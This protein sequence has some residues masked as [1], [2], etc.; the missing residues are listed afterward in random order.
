MANYNEA[1]LPQ[2]FTPKGGKNTLGK[3]IGAY[4]L[5]SQLSGPKGYSHE[6]VLQQKTADAII[7]EHHADRE[8]A[9]SKQFASHKSNIEVEDRRLAAD[10]VHEFAQKY[11]HATEISHGGTKVKFGKKSGSSPKPKPQPENT[12]PKP[13]KPK[14]PSNKGNKSGKGKTK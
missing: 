10:T 11:P 2:K 8:H 1:D 5:G 4:V 7:K 13:D 9:R 14:P 3:M 12:K 6:Q